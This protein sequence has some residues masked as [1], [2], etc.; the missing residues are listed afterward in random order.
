MSQ[1]YSH[2]SHYVVYQ[3]AMALITCGIFEELEK[4]GDVGCTVDTLAVRCGVDSMMLRALCDFLSVNAPDLLERHVNGRYV[5]GVGYADRIVQNHL[6]FAHAYKPVLDAV[7][8]LLTGELTYGR[9]VQRNGSSLQMSSRIFNAKAVEYV[10]DSIRKK[11]YTQVVDLGA[12][13][14]SF[15]EMVCRT[16]PGV[17]GVG[18]EIDSEVVR[19]GTE[20]I[21]HS[22]P[23]AQL[24]VG[25]IAR[26]RG[27]CEYVTDSA[28]T[29]FVGFTV[30]HE[31]LY[32]TEEHLCGVFEQYRE[33]FPQSDFIIAEY[34]GYTY[35]ELMRMSPVERGAAAVYQMVHP[36]T[37][38]GVPRSIAFWQAIMKKSNLRSD[39]A[40]PIDP[41]IIVLNGRFGQ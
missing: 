3:A 27:W 4:S 22:T 5:L 14:G 28:Q 1:L 8:Q 31:L 39:A 26:P 18:I 37:K 33:L 10:V 23:T 29:V 15:L 7:G 34:G 11:K 6:H 21:I 2:L 38:Q 25:D 36:L 13:D 16:V 17:V 19:R 35:D 32:P 30:W 20:Q 41:N 9:N 12:G 24:F 40:L